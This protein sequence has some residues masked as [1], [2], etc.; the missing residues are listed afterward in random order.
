MRFFSRG[1]QRACRRSRKV[2]RKQPTC[3]RKPGPGLEW[4]EDRLAPAAGALDPTF[5]IG[6]KVLTD[7]G[8]A[9]TTDLGG[10]A[11]AYQL[12]GKAIVVGSSNGDMVVLRYRTDGLLDQTFGNWGIVWIDFGGSMDSGSSVVVDR[13]GRIV[14][15]GTRFQQGTGSDFAVARLTPSGVLDSSVDGDGMLTID[16]GSPRDVCWSVA[17]DS[18]DRILA[19]GYVSQGSN[20]DFAVA[21]VTP[22]GA[23]DSS[24]DGDGKLTIDFGSDIDGA[25]GLAVDSLGGVIV[26]GV[27]YQEATDFDFAVARVTMSG[28]LDTSFDGDGKLTIDF[29]GRSNDANSVAVDNLGR[30]ILAGGASLTPFVEAFAVVRL[31]PSGALDTSFDADGIQ[32]IDF[33]SSNAYCST[34]TVDSANRVLLVGRANASKGQSG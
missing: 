25:F 28:A 10:Y 17:V 14:V 21:R 3:R 9:G 26:A 4:L 34:V 33:G 8:I 23:L 1:S 32:T 29:G 30:I 27:S 20:L 2:R 7:I 31:T 19:A 5:G 6:G 15:A 24:F 11:I 22:S 13:L 12:D 16:F 18:A